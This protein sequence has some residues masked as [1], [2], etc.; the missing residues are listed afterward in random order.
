VKTTDATVAFKQ[1]LQNAGASQKRDAVDLRIVDEVKTG[2]EQFGKSYEGGS[3]GIIDSQNDVGG[4]P[5][6]KSK[7]YPQDSD[8]DGMPDKWEKK[9]RL[10]PNDP[11]DFNKNSIHKNYTNI[12][13]YINELTKL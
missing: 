5:K 6:L 8:N 7:K 10:N 13:V 11:A 12:E 9:N 1:V 2:K 4:W 3:N